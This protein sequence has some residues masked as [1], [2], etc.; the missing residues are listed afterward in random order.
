[1]APVAIYLFQFVALNSMFKT[2]TGRKSVW[3]GREV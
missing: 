1:M 3:K 2:L